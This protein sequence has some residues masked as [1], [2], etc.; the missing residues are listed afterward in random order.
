VSVDKERKPRQE[1]GIPYTIT[2]IGVAKGIMARCKGEISRLKEE[3][4]ERE[5][6]RHHAKIKAA[7]E[8][9]KKQRASVWN[10]WPTKERHW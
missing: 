8:M 2:G 5:A 4:R 7:A 10:A 1:A 9:L 3:N 6:R